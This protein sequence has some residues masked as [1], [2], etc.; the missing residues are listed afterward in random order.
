MNLNCVQWM[1]QRHLYTPHIAPSHIVNDTAGI[2]SVVDQFHKI[3]KCK[4][5]IKYLDIPSM[6]LNDTIWVKIV[7]VRL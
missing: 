5:H 3:V 6:E 4:S 7:Y 1:R 2:E